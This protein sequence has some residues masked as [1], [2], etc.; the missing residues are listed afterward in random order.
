MLVFLRRVSS[1]SFGPS[2]EE[3]GVCPRVMFVHRHHPGIRVEWLL[4]FFSKLHCDGAS[5]DLGLLGRRDP[6]RIR[7]RRSMA[8]ASSDDGKH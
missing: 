3:H 4:R 8:E 6:V 2:L 7:R 1:T 5:P